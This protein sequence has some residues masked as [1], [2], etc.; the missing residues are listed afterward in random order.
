MIKTAILS[1][2][3]T[4]KF[5]QQLSSMHYEILA[6]TSSLALVTCGNNLIR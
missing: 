6:T 4:I 3:R 1:L 5:W 2:K